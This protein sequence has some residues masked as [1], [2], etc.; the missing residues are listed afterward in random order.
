MR[1]HVRPHDKVGLVKRL[2]IEEE[3]EINLLLW[4]ISRTERVG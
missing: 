4:H 2:G 1:S 3:I